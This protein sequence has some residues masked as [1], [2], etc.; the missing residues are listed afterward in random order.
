MSIFVPFLRFGK[1]IFAYST[2]G[3]SKIVG[4]IFKFRSGGYA[5]FGIP[6]LFVVFPPTGFAYVFLHFLLSFFFR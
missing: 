1:H 4:E 5:V 6:L 3:T 2:K